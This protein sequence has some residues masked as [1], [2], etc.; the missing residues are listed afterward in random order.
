MKL[1][2]SAYSAF[3]NLQKCLFIISRNQRKRTRFWKHKEIVFFN[4]S[5]RDVSGGSVSYVLSALRHFQLLI[6]I[7]KYIL[8]LY[9]LILFSWTDF[10]FFLP[11]TVF[12]ESWLLE[13]RRCTWAWTLR[14]ICL[15]LDKQLSGH[16]SI[17]WR[18]P[19][20]AFVPICH[21]KDVKFCAPSFFLLILFAPPLLLSPRQADDSLLRLDGRCIEFSPRS[22]LSVIVKLHDCSGSLQDRDG[23]LYLFTGLLMSSGWCGHHGPGFK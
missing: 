19:Q 6:I 18:S 4:S 5:L 7:I 1:C 23:E 2:F 22:G 9:L 11:I 13:P 3:K 10:L 15:Q 14:R 12:A 21:V 8:S 20:C 17:Q 16:Q